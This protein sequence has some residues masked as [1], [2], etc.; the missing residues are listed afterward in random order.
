MLSNLQGFYAETESGT[1][2]VA[3]DLMIS[4]KMESRFS[5]GNFEGSTRTDY[6]TETY[7]IARGTRG[8]RRAISPMRSG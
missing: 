3:G 6:M 1:I 4:I 8:R 2:P 7:P 5:S